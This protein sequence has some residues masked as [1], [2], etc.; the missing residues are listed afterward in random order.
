MCAIAGYSLDRP[1]QRR[2]ADLLAMCR[3]MAHRGP[4]DQGI[5]FFNTS[6]P[7]A[8][9]PASRRHD[10]DCIWHDLAVGHRRFSIIDPT[11]EG[12]QPFWSEDLKLCLTFNG[13]IYNYVELRSEMARQGVVF[14]T[15]SDT[16][17][18]LKAYQCWGI[19]MFSRLRGFWALAL[20]DKDKNAT[21]LS[22]DPLGKAPLY[23]ANMRN[24][25]AWASEIKALRI[26]A[27]PAAFEPRAQAIDDFIRHGWRDVDNLT[28]YQGVQTLPAGTHAWVADGRLG[29][30]V[31]YW[32]IPATRI[33]ATELSE[34]EAIRHFQS[35]FNTAVTRRLRADVPLAFEL[36]GGMDSSSIVTAA[37]EMGQDIRTY[38]VKFSDPDSDEEPFARKIKDRYGSRVDYRVIRPGQDDFWREA[39][40]YVAMMDEPFHSPNMLTNRSVWQSMA[41]DGIRVSLNGAAGDEVLAGYGSDYAWPNIVR[42]LRAGSFW[43][44]GTELARHKELPWGLLAA[45]EAYRFA[46]RRSKPAPALGLL[47]TSSGRH[48][49]EGPSDDL[50]GLMVSLMGNWRMNYWLRSGHQSAMSVPLEVRAPFL[51]QDL[52][53]FCFRLPAEYL[54]RDGWHKWILRKAM[55]DQL[56]PDIAWRKRKMG[57][58]FPIREWLVQSRERFFDITDTVDC[59]HVDI[60]MLHSRYEHL[61]QADPNT[62]WR[63]MSVLLWWKRCVLG[64]PL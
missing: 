32:Q 24:G 15:S 60:T 17:V 26:V 38:T 1:E 6:N 13:E 31:R 43:R 5:A 21:L 48:H 2:T 61:A 56:P 23:L 11:P 30:P 10:V 42:L 63:V 16:E 3:V 20:H 4:D 28:C 18:L 47:R 14:R 64:E 9:D 29:D 59:P 41:K 25:V 12:H 58:P 37:L 22:R 36:S 49:D 40:A 34:S 27:H 52:V 44:A 8:V 50:Q 19:G 39:D 62:L 55:G 45:R 51:D 7:S 35:A 46:R 33:P 54:I 53:D 57:F